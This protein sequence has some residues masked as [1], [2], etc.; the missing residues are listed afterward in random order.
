[1]IGTNSNE[2]RNRMEGFFVNSSQL[3]Q[4]YIWLVFGILMFGMAGTAA[5]TGKLRGRFGEVAYRDKDQKG[6]WSSLVI[7]CLFGTVFILFYLYKIH[8]F[9]K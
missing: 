7:Y 9:S 2:V 8:A 5:W 3:I 1:M 4:R 6:F